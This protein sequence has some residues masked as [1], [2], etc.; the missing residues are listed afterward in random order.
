MSQWCLLLPSCTLQYHYLAMYVEKRELLE[1][2]SELPE[3]CE[4]EELQY[5]IHILEKLKHAEQIAMRNGGVLF[6]EA[7]GF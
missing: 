7:E 1:L 2:I 6:E 5:K 3:Q 4:L